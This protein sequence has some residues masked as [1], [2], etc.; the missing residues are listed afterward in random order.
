MSSA[1][2]GSPAYSALWV[3]TRKEFS[4]NNGDWASNILVKK[5]LS[6][7]LKRKRIPGGIHKKRYL[8]IDSSERADLLYVFP[9]RS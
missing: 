5:G 6:A 2:S 7:K 4:I 9:L 3:V 8:S 1:I